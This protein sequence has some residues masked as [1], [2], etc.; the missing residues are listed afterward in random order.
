MLCR[1][2][3]TNWKCGNFL[4]FK[5]QLRWGKNVYGYPFLIE[6]GKELKVWNNLENVTWCSATWEEEERGGRKRGG[7]NTVWQVEV[8]VFRRLSAASPRLP[9]SELQCLG[10]AGLQHW[11]SVFENSVKRTLLIASLL[12][13]Y[14][15]V[16]QMVSQKVGCYK[17]GHHVKSGCWGRWP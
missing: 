3:I 17:K 4:I 13:C 11:R 10:D 2:T 5:W 16:L 12:F 9:A 14:H 8:T 15:A 6:M 1:T 7:K